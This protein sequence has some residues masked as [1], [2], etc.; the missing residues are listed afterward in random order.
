[1]NVWAESKGA[2]DLFRDYESEIGAV[3]EYISK[4][5]ASFVMKD[6]KLVINQMCAEARRTRRRKDSDTTSNETTILLSDGSQDNEVEP[7]RVDKRKNEDADDES[8]YEAAARDLKESYKVKRAIYG[9]SFSL[10][11]LVM[12][13]E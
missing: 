9:D 2:R 8:E 13:D 12:E 7:Q 3:F 1:M 6:C 11:D 5:R 4:I 10:A